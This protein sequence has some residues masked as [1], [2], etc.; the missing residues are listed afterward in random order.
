[1]TVTETEVHG[2]IDF[3]LLEASGE[4]L[5][6]EVAAALLDLIQQGLIR[7]YDLLIVRKDED[8]TF[9]GLDI[10][11]LP[12]DDAEAFIV[13][14]GAQSGLLGDEDMALAADAMRPGSVA[15]LLV[16]ENA[17]A[18]PFV[19]AAR[20]AGAHVIASERIPADAIMDLLDELET[21]EQIG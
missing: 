7:V 9:S 16:Y 11:D 10:V 15:A 8:G 19:A 21:A 18:V 4:T 5:K 17:W 13:F 20:D 14:A 2:P 6:G 3:L 12:D 1:M